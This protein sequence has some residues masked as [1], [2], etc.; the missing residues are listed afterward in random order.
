MN[1]INNLH[2]PMLTED[3]VL[4]EGLPFAYLLS[5][6][7]SRSVGLSRIDIGYSREKIASDFGESLPDSHHS[8]E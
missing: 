4:V 1:T 7:F 3:S 2:D 6:G 8:D 5:P